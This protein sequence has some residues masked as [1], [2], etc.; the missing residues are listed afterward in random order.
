MIVTGLGDAAVRR[1]TAIRMRSA[2]LAASGQ[3]RARQDDGELVAAVA[4]DAILAAGR[5][6]D[7]GGH[8]V[9]QRVAGRM[10]V[11]VVVGLEGV[12]VHHQHRQ[13]PGLGGRARRRSLDLPAELQLEGTV[14]AEPGERIGLGSLAHGVMRIRVAQRDRCL[15]GEQL[16]ELEVALAEEDLRAADARDVERAEHLAVR[17]E[18]HDHDGLR[19]RRRPRDLQR[20]RVVQGVVGQDRLGM[21]DRPP[22]QP[23]AERDHVAADLLGVSLAG[24]DR[25]PSRRA[26]DR[27]GRSTGCRSHHLAQAVRDRL[28]HVRLVE[29]AEQAL[30]RHQQTALRTR[31]G[32]AARSI[33]PPAGRRWSRCA[34]ACAA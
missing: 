24:E 9:E 14:V 7:G 2:T 15:R 3:G 4:E 10:A 20:T 29:R 23:S 34:I 18:R 8:V 32:V 27:S 12:E 33:A 22:H 31:L 13:A 19:V 21:L 6:V 26:R 17:D 28:E 11:P 16:D 25:H 30:V 1:A 5:A